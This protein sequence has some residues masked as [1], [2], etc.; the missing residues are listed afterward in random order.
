M[1][2]AFDFKWKWKVDEAL[3]TLRA[4]IE[5]SRDFVAMD[6]FAIVKGYIGVLELDLK[7]AKEKLDGLRIQSK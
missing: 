6:R 5:E 7:N 3:K 2:S 4:R 1:E